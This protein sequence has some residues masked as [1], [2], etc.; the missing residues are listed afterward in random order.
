MSDLQILTGLSILISGYSQLRCGLS[1]Y[2]WQILVY[3]T[4]FCSL[5][6]LSCLT[7]LRNHL[8]NHRGERLWRL[9]GMGALITMLIAALLPTGKYGTQ[10]SPAEYAICTFGDLSPAGY[11]TRGTYGD[12][13]PTLNYASMIISV[14]LMGLGFLSRVVR[15]HRA[16]SI[17]VVAA[18]R[19]YLSERARR[20]LRKNHEKAMKHFKSGDI[21][22]F[23]T[24]M[25][26][27]CRPALALFLTIRILLDIWSSLILEVS[28]GACTLAI[29]ILTLTG[30]V[31]ASELC[32]GRL[33][34]RVEHTGSYKPRHRETAMDV[35]TDSSGD[36]ASGATA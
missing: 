2:H 4:W 15:L 24:V 9:I 29:N 13:D 30:L 17:G 12:G 14:L 11:T 28:L 27:Q 19:R 33:Q 1:V 35:R 18:L 31:A 16:L 26:F 7:F 8:Y 3:L 36:F 20:H 34:P 5:T 21:K 25:S 10:H 22:H 6:H 32:L 23:R